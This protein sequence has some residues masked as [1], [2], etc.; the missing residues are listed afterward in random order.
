MCQ[1]EIAYPS[2]RRGLLD[3]TERK[4]PMKG[5]QRKMLLGGQL[6]AANAFQVIF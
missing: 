1:R 4:K 5:K 3:E 2:D 6:C